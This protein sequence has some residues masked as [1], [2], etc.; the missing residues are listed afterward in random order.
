MTGP[1][2]IEGIPGP[3][4][5][6]GLPGLPGTF[7]AGDFYALSQVATIAPGTPISFPLTGP[8]FGTDILRIDTSHFNLVSIGIYQVFFQ[9]SITEA[10]QL[11]V[12]L[13]TELHYTVVGRATG[14]SQIVGMCLVQNVVPNTLLSIVN[15]IGETTALTITPLAGGI[16][17]ASAHLMITR[18]F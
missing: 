5:P 11:C 10:G 14:T 4:G 18:I 3:I 2:G 1:Q 12:V 8:F 6:I 15:P 13:G 17:A 7:S 16:L 9:A